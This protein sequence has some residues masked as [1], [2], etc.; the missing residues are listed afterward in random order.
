[1]GWAIKNGS[2][3]LLFPQITPHLFKNLSY[4]FISMD[5]SNV[6][7]N[8]DE[9]S[10]FVYLMVGTIWWEFFAG[11]PTNCKQICSYF[12]DFCLLFR[13]LDGNNFVIFFS[14]LQCKSKE[15]LKYR[16]SRKR[17]I[18]E[19]KGLQSGSWG[20]GD[21]THKALFTLYCLRSSWG[22]S[23]H[24]LKVGLFSGHCCSYKQ[25][26]RGFDA[27]LGHLPDRNDL[28]LTAMM[29]LVM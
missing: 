27:L 10:F 19:Q 17:L 20:S 13:I 22:H 26:A 16:I 15:I 14:P 28:H 29:P 18:V 3:N 12:A 4:F 5:G 9:G 6:S 11:T 25:E 7:L 2:K 23:V 8:C 21:C 1:M 24:F